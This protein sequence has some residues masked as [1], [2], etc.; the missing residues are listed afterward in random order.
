M[1]FKK[2]HQLGLKPKFTLEIA[3]HGS[4]RKEKLNNVVMFGIP[5]TLTH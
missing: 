3:V 4:V 1:I 5:N 2:A